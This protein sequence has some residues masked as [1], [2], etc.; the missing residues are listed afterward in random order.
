MSE[1]PKRKSKSSKDADVQGGAKKRKEDLS[2]LSD[3]LAGSEPFTSNNI[4]Y[5]FLKSLINNSFQIFYTVLQRFIEEANSTMHDDDADDEKPAGP[6]IVQDFLSQGGT[7][8]E[9]LSLLDSETKRKPGEIATVFT[10][11]EIIFSR[12]N[13]INLKKKITI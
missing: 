4:H 1:K 5:P 8:M 3:G 6:D 12:F 13:Q 9:L 11:L 10:S 2:W 7:G